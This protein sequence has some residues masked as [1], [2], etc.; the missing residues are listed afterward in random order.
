MSEESS[1]IS[2]LIDKIH[3]DTTVSD[4]VSLTDAAKAGRQIRTLSENL[5]SSSDSESRLKFQV[6]L[7]RVIVG[8][9]SPDTG[10]RFDD[11]FGPHIQFLARLLQPDLVPLELY[12]YYLN[13]L[14]T[15]LSA[16]LEN[17]D[18]KSG[19]RGN[20]SFPFVPGL[21]CLLPHFFNGAMR[22]QRLSF[23]L[24]ET[25]GSDVLR[26]RVMMLFSKKVFWHFN[27][28]AELLDQIKLL[29]LT[30]KELEMVCVNVSQN[31][32][33]EHMVIEA[34]APIISNFF[35]VEF[36]KWR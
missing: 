36:E 7:D 24:V 28:A 9:T 12:G 22:Q 33:V 18:E 27:W 4:I 6:L 11:K 29:D 26:E 16:S 34:A 1:A 31:T 20:K 13:R 23:S 8:L 32:L 10:F 35:G 21:L 2:V 14:V 15:C 25:C 5:A 30:A 3:S 17:A 19:F